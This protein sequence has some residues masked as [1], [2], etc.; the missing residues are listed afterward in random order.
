MSKSLKDIAKS[1]KNGQDETSDMDLKDNMF[2]SETPDELPQDVS[3][4]IGK[5]SGKSESELMSEL[6]RVT[7]EQKK[8]GVYDPQSMQ[9][10]VQQ[11][12]PMLNEEQKRKLQ[13]I[14]SQLGL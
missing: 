8:E 1:K 6:R 10:L 7:S 9:T 12:A 13:T 4:M 3:E 2:F 11:L 14:T 5:Y